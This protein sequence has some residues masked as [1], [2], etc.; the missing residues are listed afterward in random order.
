MDDDALVALMHRLDDPRHLEVPSGYDALDA[1]RRFAAFV[2]ALTAHLGATWET[3]TGAHIQDASFH[4]QIYV[5]RPEGGAWPLRFSHF[6]GLAAIHQ[7]DEVPGALLAPLVTLLERHA[8]VY[9]PFRL[10][11]RPYPRAD[12]VQAGIRDWWIRFFDYL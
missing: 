6:G 8:Y 11:D 10:L 1:S 9:V 12:L 5:P 2:D 3:E 7:D 4:S